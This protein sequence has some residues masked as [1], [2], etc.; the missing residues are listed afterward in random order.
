MRA[1][2]ASLLFGEAACLTAAAVW[3]VSVELFRVPIERW[4]AATLNLFKSL[5]ATALLVV[6]AAVAGAL[7]GL[8]ELPSRDL[9]LLAVS[10]LVGISL[11][12]TALFGAV[13]RLGVHRT[14]L[15]QTLAPVVTCLVAVATTGERLGGR[16][17]VGGLTIL[18]GVAVVVAPRPGPH[19]R[20]AAAAAVTAGGL[21][22]AVLAAC[23][24]GVAVVMSKAGMSVAQPLP[25]TLLRLGAAAAGLLLVAVARRNLGPLIGAAR[26][27][28]TLQRALPASFLGTFLGMLAMMAG[29]ALAPASV[30]GV[31]LATTPVFSL[32]LDA[33]MSRRMPSPAGLAGTLLAV[34]GVGLLVAG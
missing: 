3:A 12:D 20:G 28:V 11:G 34:A 27:R 5:A 32:L 25:A 18:A 31:L 14:M 17:L 24:Q 21:G 16:E 33:L 22:L 6:A 30:A 29:V 2:P 9:A 26:D 7:P 19:T 23:G 15:L 1:V 4:G 10:G 8:A 13:A